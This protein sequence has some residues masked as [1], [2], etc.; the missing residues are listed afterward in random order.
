MS[1]TTTPGFGELV[2]LFGEEWRRKMIPHDMETF[3]TYFPSLFSID[4]DFLD[5]TGSIR[6]NRSNGIGA[7]EIASAA[8]VAG[9]YLSR[10]ALFNLKTNPAYVEVSNIVMEWG[11]VHE[12][13]AR[14]FTLS[15]VSPLIENFFHPAVV[16]S[17]LDNFLFCSPDDVLIL[18]NKTKMIVEYKCPYSGIPYPEIPDHHYTQ[19]LAN[20]AILMCPVA[21]YSVWTQR[22]L[23]MWCVP[24]NAEVWLEV[25]ERVKEFNDKYIKTNTCPKRSAKGDKMVDLMPESDKQK[26]VPF[27]IDLD[28]IVYPIKDVFVVLKFFVDHHIKFKTWFEQQIK[29]FE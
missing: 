23:K 29:Q 24:F 8:N 26:C 4:Q 1:F 10:I 5:S 3:A 25:R 7:S 2:S 21:L 19:L 22:Q 18:K 6:W 13:M 14:L 20:M 16:C 27:T 17:P 12:P 15:L 11:N 28:E 9:A